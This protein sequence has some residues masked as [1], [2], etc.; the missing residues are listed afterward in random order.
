MFGNL[1]LGVAFFVVF[2]MLGGWEW[3]FVCSWGWTVG[4]FIPS[5]FFVC[6]YLL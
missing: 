4:F 6:I 1:H 2:G 5:L 3:L